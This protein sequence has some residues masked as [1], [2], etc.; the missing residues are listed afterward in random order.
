[1]Y[2]YQNTNKMKKIYTIAALV[3]SMT[4]QSCSDMMTELNPNNTT[5]DQYWENLDHT[6]ATLTSVYNALYHHDLLT[7]E[8][9]TLTS[10]MGYPG[11]GRNGNTTNT[12]LTIYYD[13]TYTSSSDDVAGKWAALYTGIFRANQ[14]IEALENLVKEGTVLA[15]SKEY[16]SQMA[17]ARFFRGLFHFY[18]HSVYNKGNII[19]FDFV[20]KQQSDY[21]QSLT[22]R[23]KGSGFKPE[24]RVV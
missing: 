23:E 21:Y 5:T 14:V 15:D 19:Y 18:L 4:F 11:Y 3:A 9:S 7:I 10:D 17:Q 16:I 20:P 2:Q 1:M 24:W 6:N 12:A 22:Y 8:T 13:H